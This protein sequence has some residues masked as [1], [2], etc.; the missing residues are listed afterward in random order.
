[1]VRVHAACDCNRRIHAVAKA[2]H[3]SG[4]GIDVDHEA[5]MTAAERRQRRNKPLGRKERGN[6][7]PD[8]HCAGIAGC[9]LDRECKCIKMRLDFGQECLPP[10]IELKTV[11]MPFEKRCAHE[12][13]EGLDPASERGR[14]KSERFGGSLQRSVPG[15]LNECLDRT[16]WRESFHV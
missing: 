4:V 2:R 10:A 7:D 5:G 13:L 12:L 14:R 8:P 9:A 1:M 16:Q 11:V 6:C 15:Y 3:P